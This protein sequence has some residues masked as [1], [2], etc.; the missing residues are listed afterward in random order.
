MMN[1]NNT[2]AGI[3]PVV[4]KILTSNRKTRK[5]ANEFVEEYYKKNRK[6]NFPFIHNV[7]SKNIYWDYFL[8]SLPHSIQSKYYVPRDYY[9][10]EL[11]PRLKTHLYSDFINEKNYYDK[12]FSNFDIKL[13]LTYI[14]V[15]PQITG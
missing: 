3:T 8:Q 7:W 6:K 15:I 9:A 13:P 12:L 14:K 2:L 5:I 11:E 10:I 4:K 1:L